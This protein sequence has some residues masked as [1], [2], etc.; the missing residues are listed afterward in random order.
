MDVNDNELLALETVHLF[1]ELL[2]SY[3]SNVCE[4]DIVFNFNKASACCRKSQSNSQGM[5]REL[6]L[7]RAGVRNSERQAKEQIEKIVT[8]STSQVPEQ[9]RLDGTWGAAFGT[10]IPG[11]FHEWC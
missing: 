5:Q 2:E 11:I 9:W 4:L 6:L 8:W 10:D 7:E 1:V 3:F